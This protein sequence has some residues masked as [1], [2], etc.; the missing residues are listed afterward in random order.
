[1]PGLQRRVST[2]P[3]VLSSATQ[4]KCEDGDDH[5]CSFARTPTGEGRRRSVNYFRARR[6]ALLWV[7]TRKL[8]NSASAAA[9]GAAP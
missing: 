2:F 1:M 9:V 5:A 4:T 6:Q 7:L 3:G 8:E